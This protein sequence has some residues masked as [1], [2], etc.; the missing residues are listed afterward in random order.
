MLYSGARAA[1]TRFEARPESVDHMH[2]WNGDSWRVR[3]LLYLHHSHSLQEY[4]EL[5]DL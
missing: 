3:Y 4:F 2:G 5:V 1:R